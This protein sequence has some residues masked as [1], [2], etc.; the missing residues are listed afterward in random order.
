MI[1][2]AQ[3][4]PIAPAEQYSKPFYRQ[5]PGASEKAYLEIANAGHFVGTRSDPTEARSML[6]WLKR[7]VDNDTRQSS[8]CARPQRRGRRGC[9][10]PAPPDGPAPDRRK[11]RSPTDPGPS[12]RPAGERTQIRMCSTL[13][14]AREIDLLDRDRFTQ[15]IPHEWF[16]WLRAN[17]PVFHHDEPGGDG[18]WV[19]TRYDDIV[20]ANRG[21]ASFSSSRTWAAWSCW[22]ADRALPGTEMA[23]NMMLFMDPP[24]HTRYRKLVN[25]GFTPA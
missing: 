15:G 7:Y 12:G 23:G 3:S 5:I 24:S 9:R 14:H 21:A 8:S 17:A 11:G 10:T 16:T 18:F 22:R 1:I 2:G 20:T 4:D 6:S 25:R 13:G 19:I